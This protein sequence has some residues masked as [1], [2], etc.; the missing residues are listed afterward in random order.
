[1]SALS[2]LFFLTLL[3]LI[4]YICLIAMGVGSFSVLLTSALGLTLLSAAMASLGLASSSLSSG[5]M[6]AALATLGLIG[7]LWAIG[8]AAPYLPAGGGA[9]AQGLAFGPKLSRF[10]LG[11]IDLND[12][13]YFLCLTLAG[14]FVAAWEIKK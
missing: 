2:S 11:L 14:L 3:G 13:V 6:P 5:A 9:L 7:F 1:M 10:T 8:L 4:P 12:V